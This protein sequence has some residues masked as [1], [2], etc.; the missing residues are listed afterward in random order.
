MYS[1]GDKILRDLRKMNRAE[2]DRF[3][4][5][6]KK[7]L[8]ELFGQGLSR[9]EACAVVGIGTHTLDNWCK[10][11]QMFGHHYKK[12]WRGYHVSKI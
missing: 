5:G 2:K 12:A 11:D 9:K 1:E 8:L 7:E 3:M 10:Q 6:C 4:V